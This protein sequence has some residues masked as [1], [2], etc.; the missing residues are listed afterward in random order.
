[1][2]SVVILLYPTRSHTLSLGM[3]PFVF[4][5]LIIH[6]SADKIHVLAS[7]RSWVKSILDMLTPAIA[8]VNLILRFDNLYRRRYK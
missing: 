5:E 4:A 7:E 6:L 8:G 1:M 3:P 2:I